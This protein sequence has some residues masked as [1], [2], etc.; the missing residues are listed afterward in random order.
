MFLLDAT[1]LQQEGKVMLISAGNHTQMYCSQTSEVRVIRGGPCPAHDSSSDSQ[2][3]DE[4]CFP[5]NN[6]D[7]DA[8][9]RRVRQVS[10]AQSV[11]FSF[12][13]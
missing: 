5:S 12:S 10:R 11:A 13:C 8:L 4:V 1:S 6:E 2:A 3:S 7:S 9:D